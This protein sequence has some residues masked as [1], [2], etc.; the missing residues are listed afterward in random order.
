MLNTQ[1]GLSLTES[2]I[3]LVIGMGVVVTSTS[4][5]LH[6]NQRIARLQHEVMLHE[7]WLMLSHFMTTQLQRAGYQASTISNIVNTD[8][9]LQLPVVISNHPSSENNSCVLFSY[10]KNSDG[11]WSIKSPA[12]H[13]GFRLFDKAI[14]YRV[15]NK[16][17]DTSGWFDMT[18]PNTT[19]V[20]KF[21]LQVKEYTSELAVL[22][23]T[24]HMFH[25]DCGAK[26][27]HQFGVKVHYAW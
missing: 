6:L 10:D 5:A 3:A 14:E 4:A 11:K 27:N 15:A 18:D 12:E 1:Q 26:A 17:C 21:T 25:R 13:L 22:G 9:P 19:V 8:L 23:I 2:M 20:T 7:E 24:L 16:G